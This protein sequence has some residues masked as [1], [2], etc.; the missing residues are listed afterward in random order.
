MPDVPSFAPPAPLLDAAGRRR[1]W[2][3]LYLTDHG[4]LR[5]V[6]CNTHRVSDNAWRAGQPSPAHLHRFAGRGVRTVINLRGARETDGVY[7]L[8][9][10]ACQ[11]HGLTLVDFPMRSRGMPKKE[12]VRAVA[13][14][15]AD[16]T[17]PVLIHC[18][19]GADR[20]GFIAALYLFLHERRPL[21]EAMGQL[22]LR[23]GHVRQ[24]RTG[25]LDFFLARVAADTGGDPDAFADWVETTYDPEALAARFR[26][27]RWARVLVN[28]VLRRE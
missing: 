14:L 7:R 6:Y 25:M 3:D 1:A 4:F 19:S 12:T 16:V 17:Y 11:R 24:A 27:S 23:Y 21:A 26:E 20:A 2:R 10:D 22:A 28:R 18:K 15:F 13:P 5:A 9:R 8:E